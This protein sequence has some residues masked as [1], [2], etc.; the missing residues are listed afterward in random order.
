VM[1]LKDDDVVSAVALVVD[2]GDAEV[3]QESLPVDIADPPS[4]D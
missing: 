1:N 2:S 4:I 3:E